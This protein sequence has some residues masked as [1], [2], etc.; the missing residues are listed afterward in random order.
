MLEWPPSTKKRSDGRPST[1]STDDIKRA[2][3]SRWTLVSCVSGRY[4]PLC[5][6]LSH[7]GSPTTKSTDDIKRVTRSCWTIVAQDGGEWTSLTTEGPPSLTLL[8]SVRHLLVE[9]TSMMI[10]TEYYKCENVFVCLF[11]LHAPN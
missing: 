11:F 2:T 7:K 8:L 9:M 10:L 3:R 5:T 4:S 6:V 1:K